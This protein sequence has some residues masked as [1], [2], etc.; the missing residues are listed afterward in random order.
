[1]DVERLAESKQAR[2]YRQQLVVTR[3]K[4][5]AGNE[6]QARADR[7]DD[8]GANPL[9]CVRDLKRPGARFALDDFVSGVSS[10]GY[11]KSLPVEYPKI[12]GQFI[13]NLEHD[14]VDQA[15]VR[16]MRSIARITGKKTIAEFVES[17]TVETL[18]REIGIDYVQGFLRH[19]PVAL[20]RAFGS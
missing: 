10:F 19:R 12:D 1:V 6:G 18:L 13:R 4:D 15:T 16:C 8:G 20:E 17:E 7:N 2:G 14:L 3:R 5:V 9:V 11:L